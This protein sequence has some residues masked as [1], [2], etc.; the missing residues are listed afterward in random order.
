MCCIN[1][2]YF[3]YI[4]CRLI[5]NIHVGSMNPEAPAFQPEKN[6]DKCNTI[7]AVSALNVH[8]NANI[9]LNS[10]SKWLSLEDVTY[11]FPQATGDVD[12]R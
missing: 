6:F 5:E 12:K 11:H 2:Y 4:C 3:S 10:D 1:L 8:H 7:K 9:K